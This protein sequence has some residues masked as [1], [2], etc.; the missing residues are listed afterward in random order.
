MSGQSGLE[1]IYLE[2]GEYDPEAPKKRVAQSSYY[3]NLQ[4]EL[5]QKKDIKSQDTQNQAT[6]KIKQEDKQQQSKKIDPQLLRK[7]QFKWSKEESGWSILPKQKKAL[8]QMTK[9]YD[10]S[11]DVLVTFLGYKID[12]STQTA[13]LMDKYAKVYIEARSHNPLLAKFAEIKCGMLQALLSLLGIST[14]E[15]QAIQKK[16]V[17]GSLEENQLLFEQNEYNLEMMELFGGSK[18]DKGRKMILLEIR[19]QIK[20]T[21]QGLGCDTIVTEETIVL[22]KKKAVSQVLVDM[23]QEKQALGMMLEFYR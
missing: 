21:T 1:S 14:E 3:K 17:K 5:A 16:A 19:E 4:R 20:K 9:A 12:L 15:L 23:S 13:A 11:T 7:P 2:G 10:R 22:A 8:P 6:Q 18:K